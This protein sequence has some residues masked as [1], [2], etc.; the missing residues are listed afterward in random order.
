M[1]IV[2]FGHNWMMPSTLDA[3]ALRIITLVLRSRLISGISQLLVQIFSAQSRDPDERLARLE[4]FLRQAVREGRRRGVPVVLVTAT[5]NLW[6]PPLIEDVELSAPEYL[7]T[8][9]DSARGRTA[10]AIAGLERFDAG[11]GHP[12]WKFVVAAWL[13]RNNESS[14]A[15]EYFQRAVDEEGEEMDRA[16][17]TV[18][19]IIRRVAREEGAHLRDTESE[20]RRIATGGI[21]GWDVMRDHCHLQPRYLS[22]EAQALLELA[23]ELT[24]AARPRFGANPFSN[25]DVAPWMLEGL[26]AVQSQLRDARARRYQ[27]GLSYFVEHWARAEP[28]RM[29]AQVE[30]FLAGPTF[31]A[32]PAEQRTAVLTSIADGFEWAGLK[33]EAVATNAR[34]LSVGAGAPAQVDAWFQAGLLRLANDDASGAVEAFRRAHDLAPRRTDVLFLLEHAAEGG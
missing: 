27:R 13:A 34:A 25:D 4:E 30:G 18:N 15:A 5:S 6:F 7:R 26:T 23:A 16:T 22:D 1:M 31:G 17:S 12:Y 32:L 28:A 21:P 2:V 8:L 19:E 29:V 24:E 33:D 14:R 11:R 9:I 3:R 10:D 20:M